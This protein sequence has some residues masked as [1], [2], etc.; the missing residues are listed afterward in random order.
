RRQ[1]RVDVREILIGFHELLGVGRHLAARRAHVADEC[2]QGE[3][4]GSDP[5]ARGAALRFA[6]V[7]LVAAVLGVELLSV[8]RVARCRRLT[9]RRRVLLAERCG[10]RE[11]DEYDRH[12]DFH[13]YLGCV[14]TSR[15]AGSPRLT[16]AIA[17]LMAGARS[18]GLVIGPSAYHPML[19]ASFA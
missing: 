11:R 13:G 4:I 16:T 7:T 9:R 14:T 10:G 1:K 15:S 18:R 12:R 8:L 19:C 6:S 17:R 2:G 5:R 3:R